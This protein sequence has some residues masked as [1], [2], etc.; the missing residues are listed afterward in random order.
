MAKNK[1]ILWIL[2]ALGLTGLFFLLKKP[3]NGLKE[4]YW[5]SNAHTGKIYHITENGELIKEISIGNNS[6]VAIDNN[7]LWYTNEG[8][9]GGI[10]QID[11]DGNRISKITRELFDPEATE[12]EG[13]DILN[14]TLIIVDDNTGNVYNLNKDGTLINILFN[15]FDIGLTSPQD[16]AYD[17]STDTLWITD[18]IQDII[19]NTTKDGTIIST[20][21]ARIF[22]PNVNQSL[23]GV[24]VCGDNLLVSIRQ[25][26][27]Y[28]ITKSGD[29]IKHISATT[30]ESDENANQ[31]VGVS[32]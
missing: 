2:G 30:F 24:A 31:I 25:G 7:T 19:Y 4:E 8:F 29:L 18:N 9:W 22:E 15:T 20:I 21:D 6:S 5:A 1:T 17:N 14:N 11:M 28:K 10:F 12:I 32:C 13:V 23:Q 16:I 26:G 3:T 27:I